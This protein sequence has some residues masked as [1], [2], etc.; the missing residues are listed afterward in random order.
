MKKVSNYIINLNENLV[1]F[2]I[3]I[4]CLASIFAPFNPF[5]FVSKQDFVEENLYKAFFYSGYIFSIFGIL[6]LIHCF[7][8]SHKWNRKILIIPNILA[9]ILL[10]YL[11]YKCPLFFKT[12]IR[13]IYVDIC[14]LILIIISFMKIKLLRNTAYLLFLIISFVCIQYIP[15]QEMKN[16]LFLCQE[17][18]NCEAMIKIINEA[19]TLLKK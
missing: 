15:E 12:P 7:A 3:V 4:F 8:Y 5:T 19:E 14:L 16:S 10:Q 13:Y 1:F 6:G 11:F 17:N 2:L 18:N 9:L